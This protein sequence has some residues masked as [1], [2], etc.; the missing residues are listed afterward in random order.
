MIQSGFTQEVIY[1]VLRET[2]EGET[3]KFWQICVFSYREVLL[4][5]D[6]YIFHNTRGLSAQVLSQ[7]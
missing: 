4:S 6:G 1:T 3:V 2:V 5:K 7:S